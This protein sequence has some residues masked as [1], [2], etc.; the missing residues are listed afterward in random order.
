MPLCAIFIISNIHI[1][2]V[3]IGVLQYDLRMLLSFCPRY[4]DASHYKFVCPARIYRGG[5]T[6]LACI[7]VLPGLFYCPTT[8]VDLII[9]SFS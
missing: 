8:A 4:K 1:D 6:T 7:N 9:L 2:T 3:V 5:L